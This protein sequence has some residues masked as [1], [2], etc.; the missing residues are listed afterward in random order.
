[1]CDA[2]GNNIYNLCFYHPERL[3]GR[4][5]TIW[6]ARQDSNLQPGD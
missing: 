4:P 1:L 5:N 3:G 6:L 2:M